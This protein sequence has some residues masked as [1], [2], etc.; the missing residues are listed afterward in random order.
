LSSE[1]SID[2]LGIL[3]GVYMGVYIGVC[4][5]FCIG[6]KENGGGTNALFIG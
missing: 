2:I 5:G 1:S 6:F 4:I 3:L